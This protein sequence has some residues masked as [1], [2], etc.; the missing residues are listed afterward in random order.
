M[1]M[2]EA[3]GRQRVSSPAG[4]IIKAAV[5]FFV[6]L[7]VV[8]IFSSTLVGVDQNDILVIQSVGG[9]LTWYTNGGYHCQCFGKVTKYHKRAQ[10]VFDPKV[11]KEM[12][13]INVKFND[14]GHADLFGSISWE[15][16][17]DVDHLN[18]IQQKYGSQEAVEQ[19]LVKTVVT[20]SVY[21]TG[22]LMSSTES[23]AEKRNDLIQ[24]IED[25]TAN[26]IY[27]TE[28]V[29]KEQPDQIT[30]EKKIVSVVQ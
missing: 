1:I 27:Q 20:K 28:T 24:L 6:L 12:Q 4:N 19:Q 13:P 3:T 25:Q 2:F 5:G 15:M 11:E 22:P 18:L 30:G 29:P 9:S 14:G 16:P 8:F 26:G 10:V 21:M 23:Y 7:V 17:L